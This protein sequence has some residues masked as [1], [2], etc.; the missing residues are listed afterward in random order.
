MVPEAWALNF[1]I[2]LTS[3][4]IREALKGP[5]SH[6]SLMTNRDAKRVLN[7]YR[8]GNREARNPFF[9]EALEQVIRSPKLGKW[10]VLERVIDDAIVAKLQGI[11]PP[12]GLKL[13][14]LARL[15]TCFAQE[16][17]GFSWHGG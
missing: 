5:F 10:F 15:R 17:S 12:P 4:S 14:I 16:V 1:K 9:K 11:E 2:R 7:A 13:R 3:D 6:D 8:P